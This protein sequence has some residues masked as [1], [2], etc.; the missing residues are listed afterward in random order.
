VIVQLL[1]W[2]VILVVYAFVIVEIFMLFVIVVVYV[3]CN[4]RLIYVV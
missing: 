4:C 2:F 3:V 1:M